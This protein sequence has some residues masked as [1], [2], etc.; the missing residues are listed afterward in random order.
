[1]SKFYSWESD[2]YRAGLLYGRAIIE[3]A[4]RLKKGIDYILKKLDERADEIDIEIKRKKGD[5][6]D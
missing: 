6:H 2:A 3:S 1:M 5:P 4:R